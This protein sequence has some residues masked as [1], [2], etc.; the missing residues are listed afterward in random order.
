ML[1]VAPLGEAYA[2]AFGDL[3]REVA[4]HTGAAPWGGRG[5]HLWQLPLDTEAH[6]CGGQHGKT[7]AHA[8]VGPPR[9]NRLC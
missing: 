7:E 8:A 4:A 6:A 2:L 3:H 5:P 9:G 1:V